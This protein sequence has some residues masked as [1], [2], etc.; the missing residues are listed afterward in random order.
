[1]KEGIGYNDATEKE[2]KLVLF[3]NVIKGKGKSKRN[4]KGEVTFTN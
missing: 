4:N 1:M 3:V 2:K